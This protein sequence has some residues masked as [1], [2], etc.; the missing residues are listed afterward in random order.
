ML[1]R[2]ATTQ[3]QWLPSKAGGWMGEGRRRR[4]QPEKQSWLA[5]RQL[6]MLGALTC[7]GVTNL[8]QYHA[9]SLF[10]PGDFWGLQVRLMHASPFR[11][12]VLICASACDNA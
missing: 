12:G 8:L 11:A 1:G 3:L 9:E 7:G 2:S 5:S 4:T 10:A 6:E